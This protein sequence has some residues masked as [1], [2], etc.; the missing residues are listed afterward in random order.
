LPLFLIAWHY[1]HLPHLCIPH[2]HTHSTQPPNTLGR[3][4]MSGSSNPLSHPALPKQPTLVG[5]HSLPLA[6]LVYATIIL[7]FSN[8][9]IK[10]VCL[11]SSKYTGLI[12][13]N[14]AVHQTRL[15]LIDPLASTKGVTKSSRVVER[16]KRVQIIT[17]MISDIPLSPCKFMVMNHV[18]KIQ[19]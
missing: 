9:I 16:T 10:L 4:I 15:C 19:T 18:P 12:P 6:L 14:L 11:L 17:I 2:F 7:G 5:A 3:I 1:N 13:F 8:R